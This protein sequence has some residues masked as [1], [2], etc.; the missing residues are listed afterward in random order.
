MVSPDGK[1]EASRSSG[2]TLLLSCLISSGF[3]VHSMG[4]QLQLQDVSFNDCV[5]LSE[6]NMVVLKEKPTELV[7]A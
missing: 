5:E 7:Q 6:V 4:Y 3:V 2:S 1:L